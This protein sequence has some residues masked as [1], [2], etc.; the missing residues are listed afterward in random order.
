MNLLEQIQDLAD[1]RKLEAEELMSL[2]DD[3][4]QIQPRHRLRAREAQ[5]VL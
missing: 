2:A 1:L 5:I 3:E 4:R